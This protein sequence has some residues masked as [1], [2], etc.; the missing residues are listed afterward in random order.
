VHRV[1]IELEEAERRADNEFEVEETDEDDD[2]DDEEGTDD[3][4]LG[5]LVCYL[6]FL[7]GIININV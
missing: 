1:R 5:L 2:E 4:A 7:G 3:A 6:D